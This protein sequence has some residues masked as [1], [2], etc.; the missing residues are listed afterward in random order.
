LSPHLSLS[1]VWD[2]LVGMP[3]IA[4][5]PYEELVRWHRKEP[6]KTF[7]E[8]V[9]RLKELTFMAAID[10]CKRHDVSNV[11]SQA[12]ELTTKAFETFF[13]E[14]NAGKDEMILRRFAA[15]LRTVLDDEAFQMIEHAYYRHLLLYHVEDENQRRCLEAM[16]ASGLAASTQEIADRLLLPVDEVERSLADGNR[17]LQRKIDDFDADELREFTEGLIVASGARN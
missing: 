17:A 1:A 6:Q 16:F 9:R 12:A 5:M 11:E 14:M 10:Y 13:P 2:W 4:S 7:E 15:T 8:F 3:P